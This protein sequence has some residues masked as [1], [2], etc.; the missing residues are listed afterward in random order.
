MISSSFHQLLPLMFPS[1]LLEVFDVTDVRVT[2]NARSEDETAHIYLEEKNAPPLIPDEHRGKHIVSKGFNHP[3]L[4][5]DFP[6]RSRLCALHIKTRR[7]EIEG[8]GSLLRILS[9][10][11]REGL[12]LTTDFAAFLKEADRTRAGG[13]RTHR[14]TL[15][16]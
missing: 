2:K 4:I 1:E 3:L 10:V 5:Q 13:S 16:G 9:F 14:E 7:W 15:L 6:I 11:P 8:A 12:K